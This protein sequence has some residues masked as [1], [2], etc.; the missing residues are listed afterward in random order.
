MPRQDNI[1]FITAFAVG[2]VLGIGATLLL[3]PQPT[4]K[5]RVVRQ[6]KPYRKRIRKSYKQARSAVRDGASATGE[7]SEEA[8]GAGRELI[9]GFREEVSRIVADARDEL[10]ELVE[11][12][13]KDISRKLR[14]TGRRFG[15]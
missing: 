8:M 9:G 7:L 12:Q 11:E 6:L 5:E 10:Q 15:R 13:S 14:K 4:P 2:T 3:R 1:D